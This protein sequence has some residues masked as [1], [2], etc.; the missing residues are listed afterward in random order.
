MTYFMNNMTDTIL[1]NILQPIAKTAAQ[2]IEVN[3]HMMAD[4]F[5]TIRDNSLLNSP[6]VQISHKQEILDNVMSGIEFIWLGLFNEYGALLTGSEGSPR[7]IAGTNIYSLI[8]ETQ[9]LAIEDTSLGLK[10]LEITMGVPVYGVRSDVSRRA[11]S[12]VTYYL[13]GSYSYDVLSD[14][15]NDIHIGANGIIFI[16][17]KNGKLIAH[18]DIEK[19]YSTEA[20]TASLGDTEEI[21]NLIRLMSEGQTGSTR[22]TVAGHGEFISYSPIRGTRWS[23]GIQ[24][25]RADFIDAVHDA[26]FTGILITAAAI[27][28]FAI[29]ILFFLK[30]I[31]TAPLQVIT[32]G[33]RRI[34]LG[35]FDQYSAANLTER[36][37]EIGTLGAAFVMMSESIRQVISNIGNLIRATRA[38]SL[39][40]R[41]DASVHLGS[42]HV[43]MSG[44][45]SMLDVF[46]SHLNS[47]PGALAM[48]NRSREPVYFNDAMQ[49]L[50][51]RH[52]FRFLG[53]NLLANILSSGKSSSLT[54]EI[55]SFLASHDAE[56]ESY[57]SDVTIPNEDGTEF[58]YT[59]E[60]R[61][62]GDDEACVMLV[63]SDVSQLTRAKEDAETANRA[64]SDFLANMSHEIR[65][66]MNAIIGMTTM[67]KSTG[68]VERKDYCLGKIGDAS[69][70]LLGVI[71]D[72]LDMS[73]IE[74]NKFELSIAEFDFEKMLQKVVSVIN[75][76]IEEKN[77]VLIVHLDEAIPRMLTGDD[78]RIAQVITN[79][80]SNAVK[81][82]PE[83]GRIRLDTHFVNEENGICTIQLDVT[84][85]GIG[86]SDEQR[87]RLFTSFEQADS[88]ISR[89]FGGTGLGL[90]ISKRIIEM[91]GGSI[92]V[93][94]EFGKG[95]TFSFTVQVLSGDDEEPLSNKKTDWKD[96]KI[97][98]VDGEEEARD[99]M[100]EIMR[101]RGITCALAASGEDALHTVRETGNFDICFV[102]WK[103]HDMS[104]KDLTRELKKMGC[105]NI[106]IMVSCAECS[107][108]EEEA[109]MAGVGKLLRKPLFPSPIVDCIN[110]CLGKGGIISPKDEI[111]HNTPNLAGH[112]I[113]LAEDVEINREIVLSFLEPTFV[114]VDCA[115]NG[116]ETV[117]IFSENPRKYD[118]IFMD[119]QMPEMDG[120]EAARRI[121]ALDVE[122]A[123]SV[124]IVAM[125]ANVFREDIERCLAAGMNDHIGKPLEVDDL[126]N[127]L[128]KYLL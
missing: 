93:E 71:N 6:D 82:T 33:A 49:N 41:A 117:R 99:Q 52:G 13:A 36:E 122:W 11:N 38:G 17:N 100:S 64:K 119:I 48:F 59:L 106:V 30:K 96:A 63:M 105:G 19:A 42:Y 1:L 66:P 74:A 80:L 15:L 70:H 28:F 31:L 128:R 111:F 45:N 39:N 4:R 54:P 91:M 85:T 7:S 43:I 29:V 10:G 44:I 26:V 67:A 92:T 101:S 114:E 109:R 8:R 98:A 104:W 123:S 110:E 103:I 27:V 69:S 73:K 40:Y 20:L 35:Q 14:V 95:S 78:Q 102:D 24:A 57:C 81:F 77:Q 88:G 72:I 50:L 113:I 65:T 32:A 60:L 23:L 3:I 127:K 18:R 125:T 46:C 90:A 47:M 94:S 124:P 120:Y 21:R 75:F 83:G 126:M 118:L 107:E 9:N 55:I 16:I 97:L 115:E 34:T 12:K 112:R 25:P 5:L 2:T 121:R 22:I 87:S 37:D 53:E 89:K 86:I 56:N 51:T 68:D 79:L 108:I 61:R 58:N 62:I 116:A 84:D 76:R